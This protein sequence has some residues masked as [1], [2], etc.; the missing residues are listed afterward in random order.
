MPHVVA[1]IEAV[2][3]LKGSGVY[4]GFDPTADSL[5]IGNLLSIITLL[6]FQRHGYQPIAVVSQSFIQDFC[7]GGGGGG[8]G[9]TMYVLTKKKQ[10]CTQYT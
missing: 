3:P 8:G 4:V 5:H 2:P 10:P 9:D 6:H 7:L 1:R